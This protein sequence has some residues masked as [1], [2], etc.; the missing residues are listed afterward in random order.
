MAESYGHA[1]GPD[2]IHRCSVLVIHLVPQVEV[3]GKP[4]PVLA[5][6]EQ[7]ALQHGHPRLKQPTQAN[8]GV[9]PAAPLAALRDADA[10]ILLRSHMATRSQAFGM[11][12]RRLGSP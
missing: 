3:H 8:D 1:A 2:P 11:Q 9:A 4:V 12:A 5:H 6:L 7:A 10:G